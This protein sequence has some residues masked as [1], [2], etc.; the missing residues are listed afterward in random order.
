[1]TRYLLKT[2]KIRDTI[3]HISNISWLYISIGKV[4]YP[5][6]Q[7]MK[8]ILKVDDFFKFPV[9]QTLTNGQAWQDAAGGHSDHFTS[10]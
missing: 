6:L 9:K 5:L 10:D 8:G 7:E 4:Y 1:M 3:S 2:V